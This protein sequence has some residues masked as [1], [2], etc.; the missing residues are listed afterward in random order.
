MNTNGNKRWVPVDALCKGLY[1]AE[2]DR[3]WSET[4]FLFQGFEVTQEAEIAI[5]R[6]Y[7]SRVCVHPACSHRYAVEEMEKGI[8][9]LQTG[10]AAEAAKPR[11][12]AS[13]NEW[14]HAHASSRDV[15]GD[16]RAPDGDLFRR[17][18]AEAHQQRNEARRV[19]DET[20]KD[21]RLGRMIDT[22]HGRELVEALVDTVARDAR[23]AFWLTSLKEASA[24]TSLH[25]VH[26]CILS[27]AFGMHLGM[28][29]QEL[30]RMGIGALLHDVGKARVPQRILGK[31]GPLTPTELEVIKRHPQDGYDLICASGGLP[32]EP[33]QVVRLHHER[34][35]GT[36]YPLGLKGDHI[37]HHVLIVA[38]T[39]TY[40][41]MTSDRPYR[42]GMDSD[43]TLQVISNE[44]ANDFGSD[45]VQAFIRCMGIFPE[46]SLVQ[47]DNGAV[48]IVVSS[49]PDARLQPL[50]L[51][52]QAP[53]GQPYDK[54]MLVNLAAPA[55]QGDRMA[56]RRIAR[57][58]APSSCDVDVADTMT[59]EF[60]LLEM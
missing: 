47:L 25:C 1:I 35:T 20:L 40:D 17:R 5:L 48:G 16:A 42:A 53:D 23:I 6:S 33:L 45:L 11:R 50:V 2:L 28:S 55:E 19:V 30:T 58:V 56:P 10:S 57:A 14:P 15:F 31:E 26:V 59:R 7:C 60:G 13:A 18:V 38:L 37:P 9:R 27:L 3:P 49:R 54:G 32:P 43:N 22:T 29:R 8:E 24:Y 52:V 46:G 36:G 39:D 21:A 34:R 12:R 4:P 41:A 51:L 44:A